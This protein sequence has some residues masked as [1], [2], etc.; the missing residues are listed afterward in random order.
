MCIS[1]ISMLGETA[2]PVWLGEDSSDKQMEHCACLDHVLHDCW[3]LK[4]IWGSADVT[5]LSTD[6]SQS[7]HCGPSGYQGPV[8]EIQEK[9]VMVGYTS[10]GFWD[11]SLKK[12]QVAGGNV[13]YAN[14][15]HSWLLQLF[16]TDVYSAV[17][18][19]FSSTNENSS[20]A[21]FNS[22]VTHC[23]SFLAVNSPP[24]RP[25]WLLSSG[26]TLRTYRVIVDHLL[27][28]LS[29]LCETRL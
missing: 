4:P 19:S 28:A 2:W 8:Q 24:D 1:E 22:L 14:I 12:M 11:T 29:K 16:K 18:A 23:G 7:L 25:G 13:N 17:F 9:R 5:T 26:L 10:W 6:E 15:Y 27:K 20:H 21:P 3:V